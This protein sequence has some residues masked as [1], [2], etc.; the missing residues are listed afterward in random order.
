LIDHEEVLAEVGNKHRKKNDSLEKGVGQPILAIEAPASPE[1][2]GNLWVGLVF[3]SKINILE[4]LLEFK[5]F[6]L[7][8]GRLLYRI[9]SLHELWLLLLLNR[10]GGIDESRGLLL[11]EL[12]R[13]LL[14][15][16]KCRLL[17]N[18]GSLLLAWVIRHKHY[19]R[20]RSSCLAY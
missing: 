6:H 17:W 13:L 7:R 2:G 16:D 12:R 4:F 3:F 18:E 5:R 19:L 8:C 9:N 20:L 15:E 1:P 11:H 10:F 14:G